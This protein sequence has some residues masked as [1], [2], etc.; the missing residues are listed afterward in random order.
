MSSTH[1]TVIAFDLYSTLLS[2]KSIAKALATH[3]TADKASSIAALW[4][5][6]QLE[7]T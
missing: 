2:T 4:R 1:K 3:F 5:L 6:Y 7:Y